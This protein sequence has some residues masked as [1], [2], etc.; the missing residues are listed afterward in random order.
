MVSPIL[1]LRVGQEK[2]EGTYFIK[3]K[4]V[5]FGTRGKTFGRGYSAEAKKCGGT[6]QK[7]WFGGTVTKAEVRLAER[8]FAVEAQ[9]WNTI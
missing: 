5:E 7:L 6:K 4:K 8:Y 1:I 9:H 2:L 3:N